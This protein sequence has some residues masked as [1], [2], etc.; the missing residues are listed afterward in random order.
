[1]N[2]F[3]QVP[4][5]PADPILG[6]GEAFR[7]D[8]NPEKINLTVGV[9]Q[10]E[11]GT[12]PVLESI[13][14]AT[15]KLAAENLGKGYMPIN[16][17]PEF[18]SNARNLVFGLDNEMVTTG[19]VVSVHT[20]GGT[21][22]LRLTADFL[23]KVLNRRKIWVSNP[24]WANHKGIFEAADM[25]TASYPYYDPETHG[26]N[27]DGLLTV[28]EDIPENDC[29]LFHACCHNPTGVD[30][31]RDDWE[32]IAKI[33]KAHHLL[34]VIDFAYQGFA[35]GWIDDAQVIRTFSRYG[36]EFFVCSSFSK[37]FGLYQDRVGALHTV[38][39]NADEGQ[40]I[41][42]QLKV[43]VRTNY[44][45]PPA[46]GSHLI[47]TV[48]ADKEL[49]QLWEEELKN[50]RTR[51]ANVRNRFVDEL[52]HTGAGKDFSFI[53]EQNGMFSFSGLSKDAVLRLRK[54][55]GIYIVDSGRINVAGIN[56]S[57]IQRLCK[58]ITG[59]L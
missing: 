3:D 16:G 17:G 4:T 25:E 27:R 29:V 32:T 54:E 5:A 11:T 31:T 30:P 55:Y 18:L 59:V 1:M 35:S 38:A 45:N 37:N 50:M 26:L 58:A 13:R 57:N 43:L 2:L 33:C 7:N 53:R 41:L 46:H 6:L 36:L 19:R 24:T 15:V 56:D 21:G 22:A 52:E 10:D 12:S 14:K 48:L 47:N 51:I 28:L 40:R 39:K 9:F 8:P 44:S 34:P 49:Y 42:S 23:R 20:P